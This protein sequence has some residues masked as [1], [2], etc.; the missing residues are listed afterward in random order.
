MGVPEIE[1]ALGHEVSRC[2]P[3]S[4]GAVADSINQGIPILNLAARDPVS[5]ALREMADKLVAVKQERGWL[6]PFRRAG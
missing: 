1:D 5:K 3:N 2:I 6:S 4:F